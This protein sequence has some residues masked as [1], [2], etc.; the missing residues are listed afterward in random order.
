[1]SVTGLSL[2]PW[3]QGAWLGQLPPTSG[4]KLCPCAA[5]HPIPCS[6]SFVSRVSQGLRAPAD[7]LVPKDLR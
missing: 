6:T 3:P 4:R 1:M 2:S 5:S 7:F